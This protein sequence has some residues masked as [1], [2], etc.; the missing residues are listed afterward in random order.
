MNISKFQYLYNELFRC[1]DMIDAIP[2][3]S[4]YLPATS[5][6]TASTTLA[7]YR[8][9]VTLLATPP[10]LAAKQPAFHHSDVP[11]PVP[12][13]TALIDT[14]ISAEQ[15]SLI[16]MTHKTHRRGLHDFELLAL[17]RNSNIHQV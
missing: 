6:A 17:S 11:R 2:H 4:A 3:Y 12:M 13:D 16:M 5:A 7:T 8:S 15:Y 10:L 14:S 9:L 1:F